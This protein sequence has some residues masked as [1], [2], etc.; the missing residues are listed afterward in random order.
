MAIALM[1]LKVEGDVLVLGDE[2]HLRDGFGNSDAGVSGFRPAQ[3]S[4]WRAE[5][6]EETKT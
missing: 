3:N 5:I 2:P 1:R 4:Y 6:H